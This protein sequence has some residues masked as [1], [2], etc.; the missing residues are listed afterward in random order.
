MRNKHYKNSNKQRGLSLIGLMILLA[1][2]GFIGLLGLKV[3]PTFTEYRAILNA[4]KEA[5]ANSTTVRDAQMS[6][7]KNASASYIESI[8]SKDLIIGREDGGLEISFAYDKKIPLFG[9]ASLLI[10]YAGT[11]AKA[12]TPSK[13]E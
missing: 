4:I 8:S 10:E 11:T 7:D 5:K 13:A 2:A 1:I 3:L 12:G 6:F 9:P